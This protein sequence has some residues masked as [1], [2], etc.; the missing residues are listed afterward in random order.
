MFVDVATA[1][2]IPT[3][4]RAFLWEDKENFVLRDHV[5]NRLTSICYQK[6]CSKRPS[7][8]AERNGLECNTSEVQYSDTRTFNM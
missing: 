8:C 6:V 7:K 1:E 4:L 5:L 2:S 3:S